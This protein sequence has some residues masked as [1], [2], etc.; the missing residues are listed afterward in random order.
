MAKRKPRKGRKQLK[1]HR[2]EKL[3]A[4]D[5]HS[6]LFREQ[7]QWDNLYSQTE[8]NKIKQCNVEV[9]RKL[10]KGL[11]QGVPW[12]THRWRRR[13][14]Q[15]CL[16]PFSV[17]LCLGLS[18]KF[19]ENLYR[20]HIECDHWYRMCDQRLSMASLR[21]CANTCGNTGLCKEIIFYTYVHAYIHTFHPS[22]YRVG[23][24]REKG[25]F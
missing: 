12:G 9:Q 20:I 4:A 14:M 6:G 16:L 10:E 7:R 5:H 2:G 24:K 23:T 18:H 21:V 22:L 8:I 15:M 11:F 17:C 13:Q 19:I 3:D 25:W 1:G